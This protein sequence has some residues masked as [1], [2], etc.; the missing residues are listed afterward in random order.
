MIMLYILG[1]GCEHAFGRAQFLATL[2]GVGP[3]RVA[4]EPHGWASVGRGLGRDLRPG[5]RPGGNP[6]EAP[7]P[8][9]C[10]RPAD[11]TGPGGLGH[12]PARRAGPL[13]P[14][15][16][17]RAHLGGLLGGTV[18]GLLLPTAV[19]EGRDEVNA[20]AT[21]R[22]SLVLAALALL[23]TAAIFVPRLLQ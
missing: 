1:M 2:R 13:L 14:Q 9:P 8:P 11:R 18:L 4:A 7:R 10:P 19:L 17:N 20:R 23:A 12:L 22:A 16:D 5:R 3:L 21:T 15:V 6:L